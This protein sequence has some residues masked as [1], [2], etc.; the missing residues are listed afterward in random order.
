MGSRLTA[1]YRVRGEAASIEARAGAIAVEQSVEMPLAAIDDKR[2]HDEI[3]GRVA[4][5]EQVDDG[6]FEVHIG[7]AVATTGAEAGQLVN[8][9]FGNTSLHED[10]T[11]HDVVLPDELA[12]GF[13]G[14]RHG[15]DG[16]RRRV[17][18]EARALTASALK[19]Q[20][21]APEALAA[22][23]GRFAL[24]RI[25]YVKDDHGIADQSYSP[26]AARVS[27]VAAAVRRATQRTGH[28]TRYLPSLSGDLD[29]LR[30][31]AEV[32]LAEDLDTVL[33]APM[34]TGLS[35]F[36]TLVRSYPELAFL[37]HPS[38]AGAARIAPPVLY[39]KLFRLFGADGA[40]FPNHGGRFGY[41]AA[42][43]REL[44]RT[45]RAPWHGCRPTLPVPAGGMSLERVP[46][47][48]DFYGIDAMLLIGGALL[49][50]RDRLVEAC[51]AFADS[52]ATH[53]YR[54]GP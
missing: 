32:A 43:C 31:Q 40:V 46:E 34:L 27:A 52:V 15:L 51:A 6:L 41:T 35:N 49:S 47:M 11:L 30:R 9:L 20:G 5:I 42:T 53:S 16:L 14:P 26:F 7:L 45:A 38:M 39:G 44:A 33:V 54:K 19:P 21:L 24:G 4:G 37:A 50:A 17:G 1:V 12:Q 13:G 48:L 25:D 10:A 3:V 28:P 36:H 2:I 23:A 22:L 29:G 8:M 18:A